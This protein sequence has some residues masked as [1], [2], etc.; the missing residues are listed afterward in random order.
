MIGESGVLFRVQHLQ[1]GA[2]GI[3]A[4]ILTHLVD[5]IQQDQR[6]GGFRL[7]QC[8][9]D[10]ARHRADIGAAVPPDLGFVA[11]PPQ[12]DADEL[13]PR[14]PRD[15]APETGLADT[16]R[17]NE[18]EDRALQ[19]G[20]TGLHREIFDNPLFH[21]FQPIVISVEHRLGL[22]QVFLDA[23]FG[24]PR[25]A[26]QPVKIV[27]HNGRLGAHRAHAFQLLDLGFGLFARLFRQVG[28]GDPRF[29]FGNLVLAVFAVTEFL[30]DRLHLLVQIVFTLGAL[31]LTFDAGLDLLLDLK[32]RHF[33]LHMAVDF[34][35]PCAHIQRLQQRLF[36]GD[37]DAE[38]P[39]GQ[40]GEAGGFAGF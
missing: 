16:R 6:V 25:H 11:H 8:L 26:Q 20:R 30:L 5:L 23:T 21:L 37:L 40:I 17:A 7:F 32:H 15:R 1:H 39:G 33:A 29:Q 36:F 38:V 18:A 10:L 19:L 9:D 28:L 4:K 12:R 2:G 22:G 3:T 34:F 13:A 35:K 24:A 27:A 31:H 14:G